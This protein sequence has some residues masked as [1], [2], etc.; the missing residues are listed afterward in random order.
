M[1]GSAAEGLRSS[2][3]SPLYTATLASRQPEAVN[4]S[5]GPLQTTRPGQP[6]GG[7]NLTRK[8]TT[9]ALITSSHLA[10][11]RVRPGDH[12]HLY[13]AAAAKAT[14]PALSAAPMPSA[15]VE[16][17][18]QQ[19]R[20]RAGV[21]L[22][23]PVRLLMPVRLS[24]RRLVL[25]SEPDRWRRRQVASPAPAIQA[26]ARARSIAAGFPCRYAPSTA[27]PGAGEAPWLAPPGVVPPE[28]PPA[29]T[30]GA[31]LIAPR[32]AEPR[33]PDAG[34]VAMPA[35]RIDVPSQPAMVA[36][37]PTFIP[38]GVEGVTRALAKQT[39]G[40]STSASSAGW[41]AISSPQMH[42]S[43]RPP[44]AGSATVAALT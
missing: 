44:S 34:C 42:S 15:K 39:A 14:T 5:S 35:V 37:R 17:R 25:M 8:G 16:Q 29:G 3:R 32:L 23:V 13:P 30:A 6:A 41:I 27:V 12:P 2:I 21:L 4:T 36:V 10:V 43:T 40:R 7:S 1:P 26:D 9:A 18:Q 38:S 19:A 33:L 20:Q 11:T 22:P 24:V 28:V 31:W